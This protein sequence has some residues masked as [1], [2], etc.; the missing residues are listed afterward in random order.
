MICSEEGSALESLF[1]VANLLLLINSVDKSN[2][3]WYRVALKTTKRKKKTRVCNIISI[4]ALSL[5]FLA[6]FFLR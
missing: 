6:H 2:I 3:L 1:T 5:L 4:V